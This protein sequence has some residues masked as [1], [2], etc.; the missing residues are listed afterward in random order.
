MNL[1]DWFFALLVPLIVCSCTMQ[2]DP[3]YNALISTAETN[4]HANS[5]V[6]MWFDATPAAWS[7]T[8]RTMQIQ[9][10][11]TALERVL[12]SASTDEPTEHSF[13]WR[14]VGHGKWTVAS[15]NGSTG[16]WRLAQGKLLARYKG[17]GTST[18]V[19]VRADSADQVA[20]EKRGR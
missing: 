15:S 17:F 19:F 4:P 18:F 2:S 13:T 11:G 5:I 6:G 20:Q 3:Q 14:Y 8:R 7:N 16:E 10:S 12:I 1:K 9:P